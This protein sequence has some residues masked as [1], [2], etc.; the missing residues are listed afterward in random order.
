M[1]S[2]AEIAQAFAST[3]A[4]YKFTDGNKLTMM[5]HQQMLKCQTEEDFKN[6]CIK[7]KAITPDGKVIP[8]RYQDDKGNT[9]IGVF[10]FPFFQAIW[11]LIQQQRASQQY[12]EEKSWDQIMEMQEQRDGIVATS[13]RVT[14]TSAPQWINALQKSLA[15]KQMFPDGSKGQAFLSQL[16]DRAQ[17]K[18]ALA[19]SGFPNSV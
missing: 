6:F 11:K 5:T 17:K 13:D 15:K 12:A 9:Q 14:E 4:K 10:A 2:L 3:F 16:L 18:A 7:H 8:A 19:T 1:K